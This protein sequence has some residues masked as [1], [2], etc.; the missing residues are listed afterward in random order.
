MWKMFVS[1]TFSV[2]TEIFFFISLETSITKET[3]ILN[4]YGWRL[5]KGN[6]FFTDI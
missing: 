3:V 2:V 6:N 5:F 1:A 4:K